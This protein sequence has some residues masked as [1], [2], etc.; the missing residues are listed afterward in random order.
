MP[1]VGFRWN[2]E[3][4]GSLFPYHFPHYVSN[5]QPPPQLTW[6]LKHAVVN[7]QTCESRNI[8]CYLVRVK[9]SS[10]NLTLERG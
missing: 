3:R 10:G 5:P 1:F 9:M 4:Q 2:Q 6:I 8:F 7:E